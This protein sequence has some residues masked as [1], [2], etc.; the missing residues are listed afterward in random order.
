MRELPQLRVRVL[1]SLLETQSREVHRLFFLEFQLRQTKVSKCAAMTGVAGENAYT[2]A[3]DV[4]L[5][6]VIGVAKA[7]RTC[8]LTSSRISRFACRARTRASQLRS[9]SR[10]L[11]SSR[12]GR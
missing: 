10:G 1:E 6:G 7:E 12:R 9:G 8:T 3:I 5:Y 2:L 4:A 11:H